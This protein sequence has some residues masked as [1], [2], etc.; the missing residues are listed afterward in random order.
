[1]I[2]KLKQKFL[3][4]ALLFFPLLTI[5]QESEQKDGIKFGGCDGWYNDGYF[6]RQYPS[7]SFTRKSTNVMWRNIMNDAEFIYGVENFDD[8][9][10][11]ERPKIEKV[12]NKFRYDM[13]VEWDQ[14]DP[15]F[16]D[17]AQKELELSLDDL[18]KSGVSEEQIQDY[19]MKNILHE[20]ARK[21]YQNLIETMKKQ[22]LSEEEA[23]A[24][25]MNFMEKNYQ[26]GVSF[27]GG[28][29]ASYRRVA[30]IVGL[31][32]VGVV[33]YI[34]IRKHK[35]S[36]QEEETSTNTSTT[37]STTGQTTGHTSGKTTGHTS[38]KTTGYTSGKTSGHSSGKTSG[39]SSGKTSGHSSGKTSGNSKPG[40]RK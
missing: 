3:I 14:L 15:Y 8:I 40:S 12:F 21:D 18:K 11:I 13:T 10:E 29:S 39:Y 9:F 6:F 2:Q 27:S 7:E 24:Q 30:I 16:K 32:V 1:M 31:V 25:M 35:D 19:M 34:I 33:A 4:L 23:S 36:R 17:H 38:G 28:G 37:T 5:A 26:A 20:S 22:G